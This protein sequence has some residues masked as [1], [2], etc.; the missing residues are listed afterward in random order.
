MSLAG[1]QDRAE[2]RR[3]RSS[4]GIMDGNQR[5]E[6]RNKC[7]DNLDSQH[8]TTVRLSQHTIPHGQ[9]DNLVENVV[10]GQSLNTE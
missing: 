6:N 3:P 9:T 1:A 5:T 2:F 10:Q 7:W 8:D 4:E